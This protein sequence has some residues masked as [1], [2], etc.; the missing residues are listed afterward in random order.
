[1]CSD[2]G[3]EA[4]VPVTRASTMDG[5]TMSQADHLKSMGKPPGAE[6]RW[7]TLGGL[8][9]C[10]LAWVLSIKCASKKK[11]M[12]QNRPVTFF[13][14]ALFFLEKT[15]KRSDLPETALGQSP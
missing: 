5:T 10:R 6:T 11:R 8:A 7:I 12:E 1:M 15:F 14:K 3:Y 9:V 2:L 13:W 4:G